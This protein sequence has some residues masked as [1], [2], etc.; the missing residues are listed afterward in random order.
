M[1]NNKEHHHNSSSS[2]Q[3]VTSSCA[4]GDTADRTTY[5]VRRRWAAIHARGT[6]SASPVLTTVQSV[7][8][9]LSNASAVDDLG[10]ST[11]L[12]VLD[13]GAVYKYEVLNVG[14]LYLHFESALKITHFLLYLCSWAL[15]RSHGGRSTR[16]QINRDGTG[17]RR[18]LEG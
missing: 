9:L 5:S 11:N 7:V 4:V 18:G 1:E 16:E 10:P 3:S 2:S 17:E 15:K 14:N 12:F 13:N 8:I 6:K